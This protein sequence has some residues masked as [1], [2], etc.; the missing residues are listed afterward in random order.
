MCLLVKFL[1]NNERH[2]G[3]SFS[4]FQRSHQGRL[5][6]YFATLLELKHETTGDPAF[7][8]SYRK[9]SIHPHAAAAGDQGGGCHDGG[10]AGDSLRRVRCE[11]AEQTELGRISL[12]AP[13][14]VSRFVC[15]HPRLYF[16][17]KTDSFISRAN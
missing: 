5:T 11:G 7:A 10:A 16:T 14:L 8:E 2:I 17:R 13:G 3:T 4:C 6:W 15:A 1:Q 12:Y 9:G